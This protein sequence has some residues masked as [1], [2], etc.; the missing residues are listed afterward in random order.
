MKEITIYTTEVCPYCIR[1]KKLLEKKGVPY[2]ELNVDKNPELVEVVIQKSGGRTTVPQIFIG[3]F[4]IGGFDDLN[5]LENENK[6][7]E[8]LNA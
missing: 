4:H 6:L 3:D 8:L 2:K 7:D 5:S 1:A